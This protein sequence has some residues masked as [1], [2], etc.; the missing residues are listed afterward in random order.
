MCLVLLRARKEVVLDERCVCVYILY[1]IYYI[2][3]FIFYILY[4]LK[5]FY[6]IHVYNYNYNYSYMLLYLY[7]YLCAHRTG[8]WS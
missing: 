7:L 4:M 8:G 6:Y 2:L 3:Y 1:F 5:I